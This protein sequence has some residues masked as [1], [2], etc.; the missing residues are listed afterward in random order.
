MASN[1]ELACVYAALI[2]QDDEVAI[3]AEKISSLLKAA[4]VEF[5]PFWPGL[6]AKAL[7]GVDVKN[8]ITSVS[9]GAGSGPAPAAAAAAPAAGGAAPAAETKKKEEPK[10]ESDDDMGF[11]LFD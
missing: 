2:L 9:S 8:L 7:E 6:F 5:E 1:Q 10:E 3:T 4:N 11:G